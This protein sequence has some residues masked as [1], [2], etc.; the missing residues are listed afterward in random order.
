MK[1]LVQAG[2]L[3]GS[4][5]DHLMRPLARAENVERVLLVCRYP[6]PEIPKVEYHFPQKLISTYPMLA[7]VYQFFSLLY[8]S[9]VKK[10]DC[11]LGCRLY[12]HGLLSFIVAK[13][14][15]R[16]II[17]FLIGGVAELYGIGHRL[18]VDFTEALPRLGRIFLN[19]LKRSDTIITTGSFTK[20]FLVKQ[21][22]DGNKIYPVINPS[23]E[24]RIYP[25][26]V[27]KI[28]DV[29]S[30]GRLSPEKHVE[31]LLHAIPRIKEKYGDI[32]A[33]IVGDGPCRDEL[34]K[35]ATKLGLNDNIDFVGFQ[36]DV[37]YYYNSSKIFVLTSEREGF[38]TVVI[39]AMTCG[40]PP[41]VSNCGD[42]IDIARDG[43]NSIVIPR[44]NDYEGFAE[45]IIRLL[46]DK[47]LYRKLSQNC[48]NTAG[49]IS[50]EDVARKWQLILGSLAHHKENHPS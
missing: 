25:E 46:K 1:V 16:P 8:L 31:T 19:L 38:P 32:R 34:L 14:R 17:L 2:N 5:I 45:A 42:V 4:I 15:R 12:P 27:P 44:Y 23:H 39:E 26:E 48:L 28:Y 13:L 20:D 6:G 33:C 41:V 21:G 35:L 30:V 40:I 43:F 36:K 18:G 3:T 22:V 50:M 24:S 7:I 49:S 11:I 10:P 9:M 47:E 29:V 37:A